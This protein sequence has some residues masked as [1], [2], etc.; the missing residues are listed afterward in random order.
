M[1]GKAVRETLAALGVIASMVF[2]GLEIQQNTRAIRGQTRQALNADYQG[3]YMM[4]ATD[5]SLWE[6]YNASF[7]SNGAGTQ[8]GHAMFARLR[9]LENVFVQWQE[10]LVDESVFISYGWRGNP[11][12]R[13][14]AFREW[15]PSRRDSFDPDFVAAFEA[16]YGL[17]P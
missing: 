12:W 5:D 6:E 17:A 9:N 1:S 4:I 2:V 10:G 15:W 13:G 16:E 14:A 8:A 7:P 11:A 3:W